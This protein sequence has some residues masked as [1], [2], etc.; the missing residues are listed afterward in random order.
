MNRLTKLHFSKNVT[1]NSDTTFDRGRLEASGIGGTVWR[2]FFVGYKVTQC[3]MNTWLSRIHRSPYV[4]DRK[5]LLFGD[6]NQENKVKRN[7]WMRHATARLYFCYCTGVSAF[8]CVKPDTKSR[9][10]YFWQCHMYYLPY[11]LRHQMYPMLCVLMLTVC[12]QVNTNSIYT[13]GVTPHILLLG[14]EVP[15]YYRSKIRLLH[16]K[17]CFGDENMSDPTVY[18]W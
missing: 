6:P 3:P 14:V 9:N 15:L 11:D 10:G 16:P 5:Q 18:Q 17:F 2:V 1:C 8:V 12:V 7:S 13:C 4:L